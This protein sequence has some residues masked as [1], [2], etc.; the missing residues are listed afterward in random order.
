MKDNIIIFNKCFTNC[1]LQCLDTVA[2]VTER[3]S[4]H[5]KRMQIIVKGSLV[6]QVAEKG[7]T[8]NPASPIKRPAKWRWS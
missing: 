3:A 5:Y 2:W 1:L 6:E 7:K 4:C 8:N